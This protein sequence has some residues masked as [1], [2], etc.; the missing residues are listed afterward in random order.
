MDESQF[1][2][3]LM[4]DNYEA[5]GFIPLPTIETRYIAQGRYILQTNTKGVPVGYILHGSLLPGGVLTIAQH[6]IDIDRRQN[7]HGMDAIATLI[8]RAKQVNCRAIVLRCAE[9]L[10]SNHF[11]QAAGFEHT[12]TLEVANK[13][14][15]KINVY[16]LDLWPPLWRVA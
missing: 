6:V 9:N 4:R 3:G 2:N 13:R 12:T 5:I 1:M 11:W 7:G 8:D 15:R 10:P 14:K 16:T